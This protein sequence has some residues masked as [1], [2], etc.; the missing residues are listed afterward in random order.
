MDCGDGCTTLNVIKATRQRPSLGLN[1][2]Q[3]QGCWGGVQ[4]HPGEG[5]GGDCTSPA[6]V[7]HPR[8]SGSDPRWAAPCCPAPPPPPAPSRLSSA[9]F[10]PAFSSQA[11][12]PASPGTPARLLVSIH[13]RRWRRQRCNPSPGWRSLRRS[14]GAR[15]RSWTPP[16]RVWGP[17]NPCVAA[18]ADR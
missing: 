11:P 5:S 1:P 3:V 2:L 12:L 15:D 9:P 18:G 14:G 17:H 16:V 6:A 7:S 8:E 4:R 13:I 10:A